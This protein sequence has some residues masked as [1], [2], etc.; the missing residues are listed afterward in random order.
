MHILAGTTKREQ[1]AKRDLNVKQ[2][3][4]IKRAAEAVV[5]GKHEAK[6][7]EEESSYSLFWFHQ[8]FDPCTNT[9][10]YRYKGG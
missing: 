5:Q 8:K 6:Q 2:L 10:E 9:L 4:Q 7:L 1:R 3:Q